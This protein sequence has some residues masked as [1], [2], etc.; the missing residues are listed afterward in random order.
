MG[1][2]FARLEDIE[3]WKR[4]CRLAV[5]IY[6]LSGKDALNKDWGLKDQMRRSAVS[7]PSNIAE[8]FE[9]DSDAEF[10][11]FLC[12]AKGSC[13]EL[14]TQIYIAHALD[15]I[16]KTETQEI[17]QECVEISSMLHGLIVSIQ[18]RKNAE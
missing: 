15:Y 18:R 4:G 5:E 16:D 9:R 17:I 2:G 11:R 14:R 12:I 13:G 3:V 1:K 8:G 6:K 7:I 10:R